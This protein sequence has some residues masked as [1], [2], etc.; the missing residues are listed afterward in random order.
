[1]ILTMKKGSATTDQSNCRTKHTRLLPLPLYY[2]RRQILSTAKCQYCGSEENLIGR[3]CESC[4]IRDRRP[5]KVVL[6]F[7]ALPEVE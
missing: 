5:G 1:M 7:A 2:H 3:V 6:R 4:L